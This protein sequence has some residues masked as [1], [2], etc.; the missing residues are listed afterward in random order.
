MYKGNTV[1]VKLST[2]F[3]SHWYVHYMGYDVANVTKNNAGD[4]C[5]GLCGE[6]RRLSPPRVLHVPSI[7]RALVAAVILSLQGMQESVGG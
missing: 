7:D 4:F 1:R 6:N 3:Y 5:I 2:L